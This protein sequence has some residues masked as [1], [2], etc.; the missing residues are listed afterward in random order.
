[1]FSEQA[2]LLCI[3]KVKLQ[4]MLLPAGLIAN[5]INSSI[6]TFLHWHLVPHS[7]LAT[8]TS[9]LLGANAVRGMHYIYCQKIPLTTDNC[10]FRRRLF[11]ANIILSGCIWGMSA[12]FSHF[13]HS[14]PH[15]M[16]VAYVLGGMTA[17]VAGMF[18]AYRIDYYGFTLPAV[19]PQII[20]FILEDTPLGT[21]MAGMFG[22]FIVLISFSAESNYRIIDTSIK[23]RWEKNDLINSLYQEKG[24][25]EAT[26]LELRAENERRRKSEELLQ[27]A[28]DELEDK[29]I[30]RTAALSKSNAELLRSEEIYRSLVETSQEGIW[31]ISTERL[32]TY[33]NNRMAQLLGCEISE[34]IGQNITAFVAPGDLEHYAIEKEIRGIRQVHLISGGGR[35]IPV[36]EAASKLPM[37][38]GLNG[39]LLCMV[40]D[41]TE[42]SERE[43]EIR[44][45]TKI[46]EE[47]N[48]ELDGF[49]HSVSHDLRSPLMTIMG[50][51][52]MLVEDYSTELPPSAVELLEHIINSTNKMNTIIDDLLKLS[53]ISRTEVSR[54]AV[55]L[56]QM[57]QNIINDIKKSFPQRDVQ[58]QIQNG[59]YCEADKG[60]LLIAMTNL[61]SNAWKYTQKEPNAQI[62]IGSFIENE[63]VVFFVKDNGAGFDM[64]HAEKLFKPFQRLHSDKDFSGI[65]IGLVIVERVIRKHG[66]R[67][68]AKSKPGEGA[69]FY[70]VLGEGDK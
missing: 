53:R 61:I 5:I 6:I 50:F 25:V 19:T 62:E 29:V 26:S 68:W 31:V 34:L 2:D 42:I 52:H 35:I 37:P 15:T 4:Y 27:S 32:I 69:T 66:G 65:G 55:D 51:S 18:A 44:H 24:A 64:A 54:S 57:A 21:S 8:W 48:H 9:V 7:F 43:E 23:L 11:E 63:M 46:L 56:S 22:L 30:E 17:G 12:F 1:M 38:L 3:E 59:M 49:T 58:I 39:K 47:R 20:L 45:Y 33:A 13:H 14:T 40:T 36:L 41:I 16:L 67:V 60:L 10:K 28:R 70:F